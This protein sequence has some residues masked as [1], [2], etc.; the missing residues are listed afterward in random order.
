MK[1][2]QFLI[3]VAAALGSKPAFAQANSFE[4]TWIN[5]K[6]TIEVRAAPCETSMCGWIVKATPNAVEV[7]RRRGT[8]TLVGLQVLR[9]YR[10]KADGTW[11]GTVFI[12]AKQKSF[13]STRK[14]LDPDTL[15]I[16]G[17]LISG[18]VCRSQTWRRV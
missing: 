9:D 14:L 4:G 18:L 15:K 3:V 16:S 10:L 2:P 8:P 5:H 12:P 6:G 1:S 17:C 11:K 7:A 13:S